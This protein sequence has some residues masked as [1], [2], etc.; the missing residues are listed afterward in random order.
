M[1]EKLFLE[2]DS[3]L[4]REVEGSTSSADIAGVYYTV[5]Y[6]LL[7]IEI[8]HIRSRVQN[9]LIVLSVKDLMCGHHIV[10]LLLHRKMGSH[11]GCKDDFNHA[12]SENLLIRYL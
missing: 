7:R 12:F 11:I 3:P 2:Q 1:V 8:G 9:F 10:Q 4:G 6:E 5:Q